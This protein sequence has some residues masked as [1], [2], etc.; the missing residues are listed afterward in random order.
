L[1]GST[2]IFAEV[3]EPR[4]AS[5]GIVRM[6]DVSCS[7]DALLAPTA[8]DRRRQHGEQPESLLVA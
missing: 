4:R 6:S 8:L 3:S 5:L 1:H 7:D 2:W